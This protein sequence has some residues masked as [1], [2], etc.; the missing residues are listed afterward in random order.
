[1]NGPIDGASIATAPATRIAR[2][3][4]LPENIAYPAAK[5]VGVMAPAN[6]P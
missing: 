5:T 2:A 4:A 6:S 1:M 3:R